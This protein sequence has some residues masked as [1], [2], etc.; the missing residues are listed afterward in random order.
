MVVNFILIFLLVIFVLSTRPL[1]CHSVDQSKSTSTHRF[2]TKSFEVAQHKYNHLGKFCKDCNFKRICYRSCLGRWKKILLSSRIILWLSKKG[3]PIILIHVIK[4]HGPVDA[5]QNRN[6]SKV[7]ICALP[8]HKKQIM[9]IP[10]F[11]N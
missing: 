6:E 3:C 10:L 9:S 7:T 11:N 5:N 1:P 2:V 8:L 4:H